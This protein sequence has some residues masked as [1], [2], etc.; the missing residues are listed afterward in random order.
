MSINRMQ[1]AA[2][3]CF[4]V[5][6]I[7]LI[8]SGILFFVWDIRKLLGDMT[9]ISAR[10][11]IRQFRQQ[12][13]GREGMSGTMLFFEEGSKQ[14]GDATEI[15][16]EKTSLLLGGFSFFLVEEKY[17]LASEETID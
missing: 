7:L 5:A 8:F 16:N 12:N 10:R 17:F 6:G 14:L 4:I 9:G 15:L 3:L 1:T 11:A 13:K 2:M